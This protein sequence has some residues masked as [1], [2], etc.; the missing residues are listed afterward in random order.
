MIKSKKDIK[1]SDNL[2][3]Y[4]ALAYGFSIVGLGTAIAIIG[5]IL[6]RK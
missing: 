5:F 2:A 3:F 6:T 4:K 1:A